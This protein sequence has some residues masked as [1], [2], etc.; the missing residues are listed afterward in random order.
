MLSE[1]KKAMR[2]TAAE[3]DSEIMLN[4][5]A[6]AMDLEMAG[7]VV[8]GVVSYTEDTNG[9]VTDTSTL[10]DPLVMR[11]LITYARMR[12]GSPPDYDRLAEAY[13]L[14]KVQLMHADAYTD[15]EGG[16]CG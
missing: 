9:A 4:L 6:G 5:M 12:F 15:Y 13:E 2:V 11:A 16:E 8:P 10:T 1:A 3:F 14:Q 7:V